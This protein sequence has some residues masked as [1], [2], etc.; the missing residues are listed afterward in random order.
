[1]ESTNPEEPQ[2]LRK[3]HRKH[4]RT[5]LIWTVLFV[6]LGIG[7]ALR[8][9][10]EYRQSTKERGDEL[11]KE[12]VVL[13]EEAQR[14]RDSK[15]LDAARKSLAKAV[16]LLKDVEQFKSHPVYVSSMIDLASLLLSS[17]SPAKAEVEEG[18]TML[19]E[20]WEVAKGFD[21]RTRWR[22][23]RDLGLASVL[24]GD[25]GEAEKWYSTAMELIPGDKVV[26]DRLNTIRNA[27]N[28]N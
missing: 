4:R 28:R 25:M 18:R 12:V 13:A 15:D 7:L 11:V 22:I 8:Y 10:I 9:T 26:K 24:A 21:V 2:L 23:A 1:M 19:R 3:S 27:P 14:A 20:A 5:N 6:L 17:R 16:S